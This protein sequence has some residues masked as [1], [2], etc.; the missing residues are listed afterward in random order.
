MAPSGDWRSYFGRRLHR[1]GEKI[2]ADRPDDDHMAGA[3]NGPAGREESQRCDETALH[4]ARRRPAAIV[5]V[6]GAI[7]AIAHHH[8]DAMMAG[9]RWRYAN[10][11]AGQYCQQGEKGNHGPRPMKHVHHSSVVLSQNSSQCSDTSMIHIRLV[12]K[13]NVKRAKNATRDCSARLPKPETRF[14]TLLLSGVDD[15]E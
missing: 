14:R 3:M 13:L 2:V 7:G 5:T 8:A 12:R 1:A 11:P 15:D 6:A 4:A 9:L 10:N